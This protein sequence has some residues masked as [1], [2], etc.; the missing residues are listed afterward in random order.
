MASA[1][2]AEIEADLAD[3]IEG[4]LGTDVTVIS[5]DG[6][7]HT[8]TGRVV[9]SYRRESAEGTVVIQEPAITL[10]RSSFLTAFG[11]LPDGLENW[12]VRFSLDPVGTALET[13]LISVPE[14]SRTIGFLTFYPQ[15][16]EQFE[17]AGA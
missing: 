1:L 3:T 4:E 17:E 13:M 6:T 7:K 15:K 5:P 2:R 9:S 10:R 12:T 8:L 16:I 11:K 14:G